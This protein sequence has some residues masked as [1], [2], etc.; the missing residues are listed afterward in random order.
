MPTLTNVESV[1]AIRE[2]HE[3]L[4]DSLREHVLELGQAARTG[5]PFGPA[6]HTLLTF[7]DTEVLPHAAAEERSIYP[8]G[9]RG[10]TAMLVQA[11]LDEHRNLIAHVA[12]LRE[13]ADGI[14]AVGSASAI[15]A[16][17]ES[18]LSK[19]N[20]LLLPALLADP[21]VSLGALL[22]GMHEILGQVSQE[23][24]RAGETGAS[25]PDD[26]EERPQT[27]DRVLDVRAIPHAGRHT[28]ILETFEALAPGAGLELLNDHDPKP[29]YYQFAAERPGAFTW[30]YLETGPEVWRVRIGRSDSKTAIRGVAS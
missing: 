4:R 1:A 28:Q 26:G 27:H 15:Q 2:H 29:L 11:M 21:S 8:A 25:R 3:E 23:I 22:D 6:Q 13:A 18:H 30:D 5:R 16:L 7:L 14:E 19:E 9:D 17:F 12:G 20:D 24:I 10:A